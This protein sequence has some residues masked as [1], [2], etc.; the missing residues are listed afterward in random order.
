MVEWVPF[1][2][3][4]PVG[5]GAGVVGAVIPASLAEPA[6][7]VPPFL[8]SAVGAMSFP[9]IAPMVCGGLPFSG[10]QVVPA[11]SLWSRAVGVGSRSRIASAV[12]PECPGD[13]PFASDVV[14]V[15]SRFVFAHGGAPWV[16]HTASVRVSPG[17][18]VESGRRRAVELRAPSA[19]PATGVGSSVGL[20]PLRTRTSS[21]VIFDPNDRPS[22]FTFAATCASGLLW[23]SLDVG[24][25]SNDEDAEPLVGCAG[26]GSSNAAPPRVI[27]ERGQVA[28]Y[29]AESQGKVP[30]D[31]FQHDSSG[32]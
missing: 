18:P 9:C 21:D 27:P 4:P 28:E 15:G 23:S 29:V 12:V 16:F 20:M 26:I 17:C 2:E 3:S 30:C 31:V 11:P 14:G 6:G 25:S 19:S 7:V 1:A 5:I 10:C 8:V 22:A 13:G 24:V 32:S